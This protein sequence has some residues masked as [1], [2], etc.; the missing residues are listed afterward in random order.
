M[1]VRNLPAGARDLLSTITE[2]SIAANPDVAQLVGQLAEAT[3][4]HADAMAAMQKIRVSQAEARG[5]QA[6]ARVEIERI[7]AER[8]ALAKRIVLGDA[9]DD[10]DYGEQAKVADL[11]RVAEMYALGALA[12]EE[13]LKAAQHRVRIVAD[14]MADLGIALE[15]KRESVRAELAF[16]RWAA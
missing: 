10:E 1:N 3:Q 8:R 14:E 4:A 6:E 7:E 16:A 13:D 15:K 12:L 11:R 2:S 5:K 9:H